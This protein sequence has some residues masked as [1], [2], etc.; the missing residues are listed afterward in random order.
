MGISP[1][2]G[3]GVRG[4]SPCGASSSS[5]SPLCSG[6]P[7]M[8][9]RH[10]APLLLPIPSVPSGHL[11]LT[12]GVGLSPPDP[13]RWAP[14]GA[15]FCPRR[16]SRQSAAGGM[17]L[18]KHFVFLGRIR[19]GPPIFLRESRQESA[20]WTS[21][22][23]KRQ[24]ATLCAARCRSVSVEGACTPTRTVAPA[25]LPSREWSCLTAAGAS[26]RPTASGF[27]DL[28]FV[29]AHSVRPYS[30][31]FTLHFSLSALLSPIFTFHS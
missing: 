18:E 20:K 7:G 5:Q 6:H 24:D 14:A 26:P 23:G 17:R 29:G 28:L 3:T 1:A 15:P 30:P 16:Q 21:G 10:D 31:L 11:P 22:A 12:R 4:I 2:G 27:L 25:F 13:L 8:G 19:P 9:I